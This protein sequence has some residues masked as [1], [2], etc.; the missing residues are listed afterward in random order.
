MLAVQQQPLQFGAKGEVKKA[1]KKTVGKAEPKEELR[2]QLKP[3]KRG[4][5][6]K[7]KLY[8]IQKGLTDAL[9]KEIKITHQ[10][11]EEAY[12]ATLGIP[13]TSE[14]PATASQ[15]KIKAIVDSI[16]PSVKRRRE[17]DFGYEAYTLQRATKMR[18]GL[19]DETMI[20]RATKEHKG[21][22]E[23]IMRQEGDVDMGM[24][25]GPVEDA[26][27][28]LIEKGEQ[29]QELQKAEIIQ[30][31]N[32]HK[33]IL[34]QTLEK[35]LDEDFK[36]DPYS[37]PEARE[38]K[39]FEF[40]SQA[41]YE[42]INAKVM[43][44]WKAPLAWT[45]EDVAKEKEKSEAEWEQKIAI[46]K[47][48]AKRKDDEMATE[49]KKLESTI[50]EKEASIQ[51]EKH[52]TMQ[53][54][55]DLEKASQS[56]ESAL[57]QVEVEKEKLEAEL[58]EVNETLRISRVKEKGEE[59]SIELI[60]KKAEEQERQL[61]IAKKQLET[62]MLQMQAEKE[63]AIVSA[64]QSLV[65][66]AEDAINTATLEL[67]AVVAQKESKIIELTGESETVKQEFLNLQQEIEKYNS[68]LRQTE[69]EKKTLKEKIAIKEGEMT[70]QKKEAL[71]AIKN[72]TSDYTRELK[73]IKTQHERDVASLTKAGEE[74][75]IEYQAYRDQISKATK[76]EKLALWREYENKLAMM[77]G[78]YKA[79]HEK[80]RL[81]HLTLEKAGL[82][83]Q[84]KKASEEYEAKFTL[85]KAKL[86]AENEETQ[87]QLDAKIVEQATLKR[88]WEREVSD[89][90]EQV[91]AAKEVELA[92][93]KAQVEALT[94]AH[95]NAIQTQVT[96]SQRISRVTTQPTPIVDTK[97]QDEVAILKAQL[98]T[99]R[100]DTQ[101]LRI[102]FQSKELQ[103]KLII[104]KATQDA[105]ARAS[106]I[107][108]YEVEEATT[109]QKIIDLSTELNQLRYDKK[110][111]EEEKMKI[112]EDTNI[113]DLQN[114]NLLNQEKLKVASLESQVERLNVAHKRISEQKTLMEE[115]HKEDNEERTK[116]K[117]RVEKLQK[118]LKDALVA[119]VEDK[120]ALHLLDSAKK[121]EIAAKE[122]EIDLYKQKIE[123]LET[124]L[125]VEQGKH[126]SVSLDRIALQGKIT[127]FEESV[128]TLE[129]LRDEA[130]ESAT[131]TQVKYNNSILNLAS[132]EDLARTREAD[133]QAIIQNYKELVEKQ[134][135][136][137]SK[138]IADTIKTNK[139]EM[140]LIDI[141]REEAQK[142][143]LEDLQTAQAEITTL[144]ETSTKCEENVI[145]LKAKIT[146]Q[147]LEIANL[148]LILKQ[149]IPQKATYTSSNCNDR[150]R[151]RSKCK[152][153]SG[154]DAVR[155]NSGRCMAVE[156]LGNLFRGK[157]N[158]KKGQC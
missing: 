150:A 76:A 51:I 118:R 1:K 67:N 55:T 20:Q 12:E 105:L 143:L 109:K 134:S 26:P 149:G 33:V 94:T 71:D 80:R 93:Y 82:E 152:L 110:Q 136:N 61:E 112:A 130:L 69:V 37:P 57:Q 138:R 153:Q 9:Q 63:A 52:T 6:G 146:N 25:A 49:Q 54:T 129:K 64:K 142:E 2:V 28:D 27:K 79:E 81:E 44:Q 66:L 13:K 132:I 42:V 101:Q 8:K 15:L 83:A 59:A 29:V 4:I 98:E 38:P 85:E 30:S 135:N 36:A 121:A 70:K 48:E 23:E 5:S 102:D 77:E 116:L 119:A 11:T 148:N 108:E 31:T 89:A 58:K 128:R 144:R 3:S 125:L 107:S 24:E 41:A 53:L 155:A 147:E 100:K 113:R 96:Q 103:A 7:P 145:A 14:K 92:G 50:A 120:K 40:Q 88:Q 35:A 122:Q 111:L 137:H 65:K 154:K 17:E 90:I 126:A 21:I 45:W 75:I 158:N 46:V 157:G 47:A 95:N 60:S 99:N 127:A 43:E 62:A 74:V 73:A 32:E 123:I 131:Q 141:K 133:L 115:K 151:M 86:K 78:E 10:A 91:N 106:L 84:A 56:Y 87:R 97:L 140:E 39:A 139:Y 72:Q 68:A 117:A 22:R 34:A 104:D 16:L 156:S 114:S 124:D 18:K 19:Q